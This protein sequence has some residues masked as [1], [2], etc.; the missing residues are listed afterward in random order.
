ME[1]GRGREEGQADGHELPAARQAL[2][3]EVL[4]GLPAQ[5]DVELVPQPLHAPALGG[6]LQGH[7]ELVRL[8]PPVAHVHLDELED[9]ARLLLDV[10]VVGHDH[11]LLDGLAAPGQHVGDGDLAAE[12]ALRVLVEVLGGPVLNVRLRGGLA[13]VEGGEDAAGAR[14]HVPR[15]PAALELRAGAQVLGL[16]EDGWD[17]SEGPMEPSRDQ[18]IDQSVNR[19]SNR[20]KIQA[21]KQPTNGSINEATN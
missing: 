7:A 17:R 4:G 21:M 8:G 2:V 10:A 16:R 11:G 3:A 5:L 12:E 13:Q 15:L 18:S 19:S 1:F 20:S 9:L 14:H 6:D